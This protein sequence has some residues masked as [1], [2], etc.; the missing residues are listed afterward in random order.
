VAQAGLWDVDGNG[1]S[2]IE[3]PNTARAILNKVNN[4]NLDNLIQC[5][6]YAG[7]F[8]VL[9]RSASVPLVLFAL[10]FTTLYALQGKIPQSDQ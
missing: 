6:A 4:M 9:P 10:L 1:L 5:S 8:A 3:D 2:K 7:A